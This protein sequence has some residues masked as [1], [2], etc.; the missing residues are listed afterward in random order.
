ML[1]SLITRFRVWLQAKTRKFHKSF[2]ASPFS[3]YMK[4]KYL[5]L[6]FDGNIA[7]GFALCYITISAARFV[8]YFKHSFTLS[9]ALTTML[10]LIHDIDC[11][12]LSYIFVQSN[13][14][15]NYK[16]LALYMFHHCNIL[17]NR[18]LFRERQN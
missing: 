18:Q 13:L 2:K 15:Y 16:H 12:H 17:L 4:I 10:Q 8:L 7:L 3:C 5:A 9:I 11:T 1:R 14:L 6:G